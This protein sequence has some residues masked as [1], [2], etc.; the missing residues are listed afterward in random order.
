L[1]FLSWLSG[2]PPQKGE[3]NVPLDGPGTFP[4]RIVGESYYQKNL[5][6][7]CGGF[8]KEGTEYVT[9]AKLAYHDDNP[10][11][12]K[13]IR[14]EI[15]GMTVG[16][17]DKSKARHYRDR[18]LA[19]GHAGE[20]ATCKAKIIGGWDRGRGDIGYFGVT[21]DL[22]IEFVEP[23]IKSGQITS[24]SEQTVA[25]DTIVFD[26]EKCQP[27]ELAQC[28]VGDHVNLWVSKG[29]VR[30]V[31][32]Y[33][34][35]TI[36]GTGKIGYVPSKYYDIVSAHL[37]KGLKCETEILEADVKNLRCKIRCRLTS[38]KGTEGEGSSH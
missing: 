20:T 1:G 19:S 27:D 17:L 26:V 29:D 13:A 21:L 15:S 4:V 16:H 12:N 33:R 11:D 31:Y 34:R 8:T 6:K 28:H 2:Q 9:T 24:D 32:I 36:G 38:P 23:L 30:K 22:P 3:Q 25:P 35:G 37:T 14:V 10:H 7:I 18:M 5:S